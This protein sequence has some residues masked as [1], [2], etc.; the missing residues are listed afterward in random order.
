[1]SEKHEEKVFTEN[2]SIDLNIFEKTEKKIK[3]I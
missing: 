1:M 3:L 2:I